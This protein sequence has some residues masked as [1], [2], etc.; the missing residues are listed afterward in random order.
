MFGE[1]YLKPD[2][3]LKYKFWRNNGNIFMSEI[4]IFSFSFGLKV[5]TREKV[6]KGAFVPQMF[7]AE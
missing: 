6:V 5:Y 2:F 1:Q 4:L 3:Y 7:S